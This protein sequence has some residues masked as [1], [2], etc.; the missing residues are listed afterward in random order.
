MHLF[1]SIYVLSNIYLVNIILI[2]YEIVNIQMLFLHCL[3]DIHNVALKLY[4]S[5]PSKNKRLIIKSILYL[6]R[7]PEIAF[8]CDFLGTQ[9]NFTIAVFILTPRKSLWKAISGFSKRYKSLKFIWVFSCCLLN[10]L[11]SFYP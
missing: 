6:L 4:I 5:T 9:R 7:V 2:K 11:L 10:V 8:Y 3:K 1:Y